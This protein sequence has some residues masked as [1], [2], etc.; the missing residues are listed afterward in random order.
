MQTFKQRI[1]GAAFSHGKVGRSQ[2]R[3]AHILQQTVRNR[4]MRLESIIRWL[5]GKRLKTVWM[6][7]QK[8]RTEI[9]NKTMGLPHL[10]ASLHFLGLGQVGAIATWL[11][12]EQFSIA[13]NRRAW[14]CPA[15]RDRRRADV[16]RVIGSAKWIA[17]ASKWPQSCRVYCWCATAKGN[18]P[19]RQHGRV[20]LR[21]VRQPLLVCQFVNYL[22]RTQRGTASVP[23]MNLIRLVSV[24]PGT[25]KAD[26]LTWAGNYW[27]IKNTEAME[28]NRCCGMLWNRIWSYLALQTCFTSAVKAA[29]TKT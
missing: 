6:R 5:L 15:S 25:V 28:N 22:R 20:L 12:I 18:A 1:R 8:T 4:M 26:R 13:R 23:A 27:S 24:S 29:R 10:T 14:V 9:A 19:V 7:D 17:A 2:D 16:L 11:L 21:P 3:L